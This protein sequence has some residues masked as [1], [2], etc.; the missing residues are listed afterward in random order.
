[1]NGHV[2]CVVL[3]H[4][5][6]RPYDDPQV[7]KRQHHQGT[8]TKRSISASPSYPDL[9]HTPF[10]NTANRDFALHSLQSVSLRFPISTTGLIPL[11]QWQE[12]QHSLNLKKTDLLNFLFTFYLKSYHEANRWCKIQICTLST[13]GTEN[14]YILHSS[15]SNPQ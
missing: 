14:Q 9:I 13:V 11:I 3:C 1:M 2:R 4:S 7:V 8:E 15:F 12:S 10:C 6:S 5:L